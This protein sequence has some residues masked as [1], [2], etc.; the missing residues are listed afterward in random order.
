[1]LCIDWRVR[2]IDGLIGP[3]KSCMNLQVPEGPGHTKVAFHYK[4]SEW[5]GWSK[6]V[7]KQPEWGPRFM[8]AAKVEYLT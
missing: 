1:M 6:L 8:K 2:V 5:K 7:K 3:C 4:Y